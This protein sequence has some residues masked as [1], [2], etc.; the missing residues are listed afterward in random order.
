M[1]KRKGD[2]LIN[3]RYS[4]FKDMGIVLFYGPARAGPLYEIR[5]EESLCVSAG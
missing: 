1:Q 3:L 4:N 5:I 2:M